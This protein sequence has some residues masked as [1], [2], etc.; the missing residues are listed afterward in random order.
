MTA[1][2]SALDSLRSELTD[3]QYNEFYEYFDMAAKQLRNV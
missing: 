3:E 1:M 2:T